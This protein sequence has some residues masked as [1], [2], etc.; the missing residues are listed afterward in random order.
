MDAAIDFVIE[1]A[2]V[3]RGQTVSYSRVF[4]AAGMPPPQDLHFGGGGELVTRF[5]KGF[6]DRCRSR[7]LPPLDALVV[8]VTG[9]REGRPGS[10]YFKMNGLKDPFGER[11]SA[12]QVMTAWA[13]WE[14]EQQQCRE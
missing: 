6:H 3:D 7:E 5:M 13:H 4:E 1:V 9:T 14:H 8:H 10:G 2:A 11:A 12:E